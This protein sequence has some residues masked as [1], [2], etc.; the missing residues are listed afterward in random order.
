M[1]KIL[2]IA[3]TGGHNVQLAL[4]RDALSSKGFDVI[5]VRTKVTVDEKDDEYYL[6]D[7]ISRS[8]LLYAPIVIQQIIKILVETKVDVV[9]STG[10]LP[11]LV[12][13]ICGRIF[14]K[15]TIWVDSIA[16]SR[17]V[18]LSGRIAEYIAHHTFT[19]WADLETEKIKYYGSIL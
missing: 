1:K 18:S 17:K 16:N 8:N 7:E 13:I 3:S 12:A 6:I 11:G 5:K 10:A 2:A 19:Q 15:K 14:S 4:I 9:L